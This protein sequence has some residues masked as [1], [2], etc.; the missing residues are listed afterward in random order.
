MP[1]RGY[2]DPIEK[3]D[4]WDDFLVTF[5]YYYPYSLSLQLK[6]ERDKNKV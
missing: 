4:K 5:C 2:P 1:H 3:F 6:G